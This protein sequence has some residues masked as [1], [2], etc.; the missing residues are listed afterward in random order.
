M[1]KL[2]M[3]CPAGK[4]VDHIN[5]DKLDNR[6]TNLRICT[7]NQNS[8]NRVPNRSS[9]SK[10][11]GVDYDTRTNVWRARIRHNYKHIFLGYYINEVDAAAAYNTAAKEYHGEYAKLN[12]L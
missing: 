11:K 1:H 5:G 8:K 6:K 9:R 7:L 10:Y 3:A 12:D 2:I 4:V